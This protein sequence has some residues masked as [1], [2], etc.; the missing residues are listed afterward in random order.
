MPYKDCLF[1]SL[2]NHSPV[3]G[4][5]RFPSPCAQSLKL[6]CRDQVTGKIMFWIHVISILAFFCS[7]PSVSLWSIANQW[8]GSDTLDSRDISKWC[9]STI[10]PIALAFPAFSVHKRYHA[11]TLRY[12]RYHLPMKLKSGL[13]IFGLMN[14]IPWGKWGMKCSQLHSVQHVSDSFS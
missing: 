14:T 3:F 1:S 13:Y 12:H 5:F 7:F 4:L 9:S 6:P 11:K 8:R 2:M 10:P